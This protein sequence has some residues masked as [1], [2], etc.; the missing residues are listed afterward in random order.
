M[1]DA[2]ELHSTHNIWQQATCAL[3]VSHVRAGAHVPTCNSVHGSSSSRGSGSRGRRVSGSSRSGSSS[4]LD[5]RQHRGGRTPCLEVHLYATAPFH[6][7]P[8][9][10]GLWERA[11][12]SRRASVIAGGGDAVALA[13]TKLL[14]GLC[15]L[16]PLEGRQVEDIVVVVPIAHSH[17]SAGRLWA[18]A[19]SR[20]Q[21]GGV[22]Q[23]ER[24]RAR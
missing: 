19:G 7:M 23:V 3:P 13:L 5:P 2:R 12:T 11:R 10:Q 6:G 9:L 15:L 16:P 18:A 1:G 14:A 22:K 24:G 8:P 4:D 20:Q 17:C 21:V